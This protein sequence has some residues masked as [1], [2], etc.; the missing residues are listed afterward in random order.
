MQ[1]A[2]L[3][4]QAA[5]CGYCVNGIVMTTAGLLAA[6][7]RP[8]A[9]TIRSTLDAHVCRCGAH[10]RMLR[11][12]ERLAG[13]APPPS[14]Q[15]L[16]DDQHHAEHAA[17]P[18]TFPAAL[19]RAPHIEDWLRPLP[20]GRIEVHS[21]RSELGQGIR[22]ASAQIVAAELDVPVERVV[23]TSAATDV[24]PHEGYTAGSSSLEQGGTVLAMAAA[25]FRRLRDAGL[26][27][28]GPIHSGDQPRWSGRT[29]GRSIRR[30]DLPH[31]VTGAPAYVHDLAPPG[32]LY[33]RAL[34]PP[35]YDATL[36][37]TDVQTVRAMPGVEAVIHDGRLLVVVAAREEQAVAAVRRLGRLTRWKPTPA[38]PSNGPS[39]PDGQEPVRQAVVD[40]PGVTKALATGR[41]VRASY[42]KPYEAHASVAPSS[43]V[44]RLD[45]DGTLTVWT[46][47]QGVYPAAKGARRASWR[48]R[49]PDRRPAR[50]RPGLL[51]AQ[52]RGRRGRLRSGGGT[53]GPRPAGAVPVLRPRRVRVGAVRP[54]DVGGRRG[55]P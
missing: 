36:L 41:R 27:P 25:A 18:P 30:T 6:N 13:Q 55:D 24:T 31:K 4:E 49:G 8:D 47:S 40:E 9:A 10:H 15:T 29:M 28:V 21:G 3:D 51:R 5:Q 43:A 37:G 2:F 39:S 53:R 48:G 34:L 35:T 54:G 50:R 12:V 52:R 32:L 17:A 26:P 7:P 45:P 16:Q 33:A 11:A 42:R 44:A 23:V 14:A 22:T 38:E 1:Q 20:D 46:H 19:R